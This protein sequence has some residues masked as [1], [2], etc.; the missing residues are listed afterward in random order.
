MVSEHDVMLL[1]RLTDGDDYSS[2]FFNA[3]HINESRRPSAQDRGRPSPFEIRGIYTITT[4]I[5]KT[6]V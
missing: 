3:P 1:D 4:R 6:T 5:T 2:H